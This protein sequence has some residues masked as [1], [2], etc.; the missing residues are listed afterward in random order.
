DTWVPVSW[1]AFLV[2][3][4]E[5]GSSGIV[6][7]KMGHCGGDSTGL[8]STHTGSSAHRSTYVGCTH[9]PQARSDVHSALHPRF[10]CT[11]LQ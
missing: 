5:L 1:S 9:D 2:T 3:K 11:I 10:Y 6:Q 8:S 7:V 4:Q